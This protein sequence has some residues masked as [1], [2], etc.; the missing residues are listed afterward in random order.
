MTKP[1]PEGS[2]RA[3]TA[4][5]VGLAWAPADHDVARAERFALTQW[6]GV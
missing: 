2:E 4:S 6:S 3:Q 5:D 1:A